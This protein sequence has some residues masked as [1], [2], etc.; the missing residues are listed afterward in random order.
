MDQGLYASPAGTDSTFV[1]SPPIESIQQLENG[2]LQPPKKKQKRNKPTLSCEECV[3]RKTKVSQSSNIN[4][5]F[6]ASGLKNSS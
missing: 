3:E 5:Q 4:F 1:E 6:S 2:T